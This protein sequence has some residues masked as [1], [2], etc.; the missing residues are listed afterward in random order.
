MKTTTCEFKSSANVRGLG[1]SLFRLPNFEILI[2]EE[3]CAQSHWDENWI[4]ERGVM[5]TRTKFENCMLNFHNQ[6]FQKMRLWCVLSNWL[7]WPATKS[8]RNTSPTTLV[9]LQSSQ[10]L[11]NETQI[12]FAKRNS[13][14]SLVPYRILTGP[15]PRALLQDPYWNFNCGPHPPKLLNGMP[16]S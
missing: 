9:V 2:W 3:R 7:V 15:V 12:S 13:W 1:C 6:I 8:I 10:K 4:L 14:F 5:L 16:K 11:R